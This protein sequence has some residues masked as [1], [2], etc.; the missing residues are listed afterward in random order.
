MPILGYYPAWNK[1]D[2]KKLHQHWSTLLITNSNVAMDTFFTVSG[3]MVSYNLLRA[4]DK[5]KNRFLSIVISFLRGLLRLTPMYALI[6]GFAATL[7]PFLGTGPYSGFIND[8]A[9][10]C[11][12]NWWTNLL[13][14]NNFVN[15]TFENMCLTDS[16]YFANEMQ[17]LLLSPLIILSLWKW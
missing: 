15:A 6:I 14:V 11:Q 12:K 16:W 4:V 8:S 7:W 5:Y 2:L 1:V 10:S 13:Y 17:F 3:L 9:S